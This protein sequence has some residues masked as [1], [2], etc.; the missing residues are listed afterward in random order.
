M[1]PVLRRTGCRT[2]LDHEYGLIVERLAAK[3]R[4]TTKFVAFADTAADQDDVGNG[5]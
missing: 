3:R 2:V 4:A 5:V 1:M